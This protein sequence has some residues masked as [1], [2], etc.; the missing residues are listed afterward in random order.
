MTDT[1]IPQSL[2]AGTEYVILERIAG[3]GDW[4]EVVRT[5]SRTSEGAVRKYLDTADDRS[6]T[7]VAIPARSWKPVTVRAQTVTTLKFEEAK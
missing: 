3:S 5:H 6:G 1:P 7:F 4:S 2:D